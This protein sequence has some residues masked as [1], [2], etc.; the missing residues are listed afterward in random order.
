MDSTF[1]AQIF[2]SVVCKSFHSTIAASLKLL[3]R[4]DSDKGREFG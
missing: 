3:P 2:V 1:L 4:I